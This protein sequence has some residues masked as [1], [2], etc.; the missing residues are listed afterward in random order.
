M[1]H[2]KNTKTIP[3][4]IILKKNQNLIGGISLNNYNRKN[5]STEIGY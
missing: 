3:F 4:G 5:K 1:W 2:G